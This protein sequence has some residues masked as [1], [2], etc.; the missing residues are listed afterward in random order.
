MPIETNSENLWEMEHLSNAE[1][2]QCK[3]KL[4]DSDV[5]K[6]ASVTSSRG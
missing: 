6:L 4:F 3:K 2:C 5:Q 1:C